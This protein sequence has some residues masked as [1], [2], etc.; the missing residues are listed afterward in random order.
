MS[1]HHLHKFSAYGVELEYMIVDRNSLAI[2]PIAD[3]ILAD[4]AGGSFDSYV[5]GE[6]VSWS[7]ELVLHVIEAKTNGPKADFPTLMRTLEAEVKKVNQLAA[8]HGC[9]LLPTAMHPFFNPEAEEVALWPHDDA[10]IYNTYN[11]IFNCHGHG[12]A[13]LQSTHINLPFYDD[14]EFAS[15][16]TAIRVVLPLIAPL[17]AS[18]PV[19]A[20]ELTGF[21]D[22]RLRYYKSNQKIIP[23]IAGHLIP[24]PVTSRRQYQDE[25]LTPMYRDVAAY[26]PEGV[27]QHEWLNSRAAI[28]RFM[29]NAVE[30]R[31]VDIQECI[32][33]DLSI[34]AMLTSLVQC[35]DAG[36]FGSFDEQLSFSS[37]ELHDIM[38]CGIKG[39]MEA[40][41]PESS[42]PAL[43]L[44][45][46]ASCSTFKDL[47]HGIYE[48][49]RSIPN[50][51]IHQWHN[52]S[53]FLLQHGN[54]SSRVMKALGQTP[55]RQKILAVYR[56]L[57]DC[58]A[59]NR[60]FTGPAA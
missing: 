59:G 36:H 31:L 47:W 44:G 53:S 35:L 18:S 48:K 50:L 29:R 21:H 15:V 20:G 52:E 40:R 3:K 54:L 26:D 32:R 22:N 14:A 10:T 9:M 6:E 55:S 33:A 11:R 51:S 46:A 49:M 13:N 38:Q 28:A 60:M 5:E 1:E 30:I 39:G 34:V 2:C 45:T 24:E 8:R 19:V 17:A 42:Y 23:T 25:I 57:G 41:L 43:F 4:M 58:L 7:N 12:W 56:E 16:H 27:I 37:Q